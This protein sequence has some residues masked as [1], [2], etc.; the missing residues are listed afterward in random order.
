MKTTAKLYLNWSKLGGS[1]EKPW[2]K[3]IQ[4]L[5]RPWRNH[6][7]KVVIPEEIIM[8]KIYLVRLIKVI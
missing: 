1:L 7:Q 6:T 8:S 4:T 2:R 3:H 5:E